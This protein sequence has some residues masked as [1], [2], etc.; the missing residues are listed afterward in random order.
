M[1]IAYRIDPERQLVL[2]HAWGVL[3][4]ADVL[5]HKGKLLRDAAFDP[6][7]PEL[8]DIRTIERLDVT[9]AGVRAMVAHDSVHAP[10]S[11]GRRLA[12][13]VPMDE[14]YG[15]ARMYELMSQREDSRVGVFR[16]FAEAEAWLGAG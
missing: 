13:V 5:A 14:A 2:T 1:P 7:M 11:P 3:T 15:M 8:S 16:T 6:R 10:R 12:L 4:D 9:A